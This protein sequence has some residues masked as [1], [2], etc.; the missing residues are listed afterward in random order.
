MYEWFR[1]SQ[2]VVSANYPACSCCHF[3]GEAQGRGYDSVMAREWDAVVIGAGIIGC[4]VA[5][6]LARRGARTAIV[7]SRMAGA[8]ATRASAGVLAP[9]IEA[10]DAGPLH[11]L[12]VRSLGLYDEFIAAIEQDICTRIEYRRCGTLEIA[13]DQPSASRL[14][15]LASWAQSEGVEAR[16]LDGDDASRLEPAL[17]PSHGALLVD[18]HGYVRAG[19]LTASLLEAAGRHGATFLPGQAVDRIDYDDRT[20][21]V[22]AG[23][24]EHRAA[25]VVIA[26]GSWSSS[27]APEGPPVKPIRGQLLRLAWNGPPVTRVLWGEHCYVVPWRN[28]TLLVGATVE[29][30]GFDERTTAEGVEGLLAAVRSLLPAAANAPLVEA[31]A[32]LRPATGDGLPII[33]RSATHPGIVYATGHYRNGILLAPLTALLVGDLVLDG[34]TDAA[35]R[36]TA[37]GRS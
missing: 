21:T 24:E 19:Q 1:R 2:D 11:E 26:A 35:L 20:V 30:V 6:E 36:L 16:W 4:A 37:P 9:Y 29:D 33:G 34:R 10:P 27:L 18:M 25:T 15:G 7:D 28:G 5:R 23:E 3:R 22:R 32:G 8:G 12:T 14:A 13:G 31:R 17:G